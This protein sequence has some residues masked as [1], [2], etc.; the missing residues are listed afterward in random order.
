MSINSITAAGAPTPT[1]PKREDSSLGKDQFLS[2]LVAQLQNQDPMAPSDNF[3][4]MGQLAQFSTLE[5]IT[6]VASEVGRLR[7]SDQLSQSVALIGKTV[8]YIGD[9]EQPAQGVV[10]KVTVVDG[11]IE[12][13]I[14]GKTVTPSQITTVS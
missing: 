9:D 10:S 1:Q 12:M 2:L 7:E 13:T 4:Y 14:D 5:Q 6:N 8:G 3:E 11:A